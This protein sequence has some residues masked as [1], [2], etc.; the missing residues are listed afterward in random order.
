MSWKYVRDYHPDTDAQQDQP[1]DD[2]HTLPEFLTQSHPC[3]QTYHSEGERDQS[4]HEYREKH[5]NVEK[6]NRQ[7]DGKGVYAGG[8]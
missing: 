6:S 4:D 3:H 1:S 7:A 2:F 8:D 5:R